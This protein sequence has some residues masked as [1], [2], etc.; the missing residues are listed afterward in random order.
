MSKYWAVPVHPRCV[1]RYPDGLIADRDGLPW[2]ITAAR[3][4][5]PYAL[6]IRGARS[7]QDARRR[8]RDLSERG[9]VE[10]YRPPQEKIYDW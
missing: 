7:L 1:W 8:F 5:E 9:V 2:Y 4:V 10:Q 6:P 3:R